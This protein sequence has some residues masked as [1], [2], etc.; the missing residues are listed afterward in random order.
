MQGEEVKAILF[1]MDGVLV[2]SL[3]AWCCVFNA[4]LKHFGFK[5]LLKKEFIKDFGAPIEHD[6]KKYFK[7]E[8]IKKVE[9][10][11]NLKFK[12]GIK[13]IRL[14]PQSIS[15]LKKLKKHPIKIGLITNSTRFI[16]NEILNHFKLK[17]YFQAI[18][19]MD[20]V[21]RRKP[22][23]D[24]IL[25]ACKKLKVKPK[26]TILVGDTM[27][28]MIAGRRAGCISVGY[29]VKGDYKINKLASITRFLNRKFFIC[30]NINIC[31][32]Q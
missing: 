14:F 10:I 3:D 9:H 24:M 27:N 13:Q 22:A 19:T 11:Y 23:P 21:K 15:T 1:D 12:K 4:T 8:T 17:K 6:V 25:K 16:T 20:D 26:N 29:K 30:L 28:D 5:P 31:L 7:G 32:W 18:V 2:D